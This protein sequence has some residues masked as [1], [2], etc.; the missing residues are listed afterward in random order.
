MK[1]LPPLLHIL[2]LVIL[3]PKLLHGHPDEP[4]NLKDL[5]PDI[6]LLRVVKLVNAKTMQ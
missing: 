5:V 3:V 2:P 1:H 4:R 6:E